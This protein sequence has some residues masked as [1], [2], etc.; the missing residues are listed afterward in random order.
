MTVDSGARIRLSQPEQG[1]RLLTVVEPLASY[2]SETQADESRINV[3]RLV[4]LLGPIS[5]ELALVDPQLAAHARTLLPDLDI[6]GP[7]LSRER[8]TSVPQASSSPTPSISSPVPSE[9]TIPWRL[10]GACAATAVAVS[11]V[12]G[13]WTTLTSDNGGPV[14]QPS[15]EAGATFFSTPPIEPDLTPDELAV[16]EADALRRPRS[17]LAREA[18]GNA[19]FQLGRHRDAEAEFRALVKLSPSDDFAHYALGRVLET[20]GRHGEAALQLK[21]AGSLSKTRSAS[22]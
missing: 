3:V 10:L 5:P 11:A 16:L 18:L 22:R 13:T 17:P 9:R 2:D 14:P 1:T 8:A 20:Q 6:T 4:D 21:L 12:F 19:Y 7:T 15:P